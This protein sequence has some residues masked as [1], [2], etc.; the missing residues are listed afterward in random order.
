MQRTAIVI[1]S[2][3][4]VGRQLIYQ[5]LEHP[6]Y[7]RVISF[8]RSPLPIT[9]SRLVQKISDFKNINSLSPD[10]TGDDLFCCLGTTIKKAGS[11]D[12]FTAI[13][14]TLVVDL[15]SAAWKAGVKQ[16]IGV[17]SI[18]AGARSGNFYLRTKGKME[19]AVMQMPFRRAILVRPSLL[20]GNR[21]E[22]RFA[23]AFSKGAMKVLGFFFVGPLR[24]YRGIE[25]ADVARAMI[26]A[27]MDEKINGIV[28]SDQLHILAKRLKNG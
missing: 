16:F 13:D 14:L 24:K 6:A 7:D 28:E 18:G 12:A 9:H 5:L 26:V 11:Q 4:L 10:M 21:N 8:S 20:L 3:G 22:W 2:T 19:E 25:A 15:A 23:E 17:S 27:A 1:G